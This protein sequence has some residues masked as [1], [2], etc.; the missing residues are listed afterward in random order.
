M[1]V[2]G[3]PKIKRDDLVF[4][5]DTYFNG[6]PYARAYEN[7]ESRYYKGQPTINFQPMQSGL[8]RCMQSPVPN[9]AA[10]DIP[11]AI[12]CLNRCLQ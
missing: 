11:A 9:S 10:K 3:G 12:R 4:G 1:G 6:V 7:L 8:H 5:F 2:A